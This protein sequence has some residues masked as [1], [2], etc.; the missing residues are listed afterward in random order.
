[1]DTPVDRKEIYNLVGIAI[2]SAQ[3]FEN[4]FVLTAKYV[5]K[6]KYADPAEAFDYKI[7]KQATSSI[8]K[9]LGNTQSIDTELSGR[10]S[11]LLEGRHKIVHRAFLEIGWPH[12]IP[13]CKLIEFRSLCLH[14]ASES[15]QL[16]VILL[17]LL[18]QWIKRFPELTEFMQ[19]TELAYAETVERI[20][21]QTT[22]LI[23]P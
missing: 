17:E 18:G 14:V 12:E 11:L 16:A 3:I 13:E 8:L 15:Q 9:E 6:N 4:V 19:E 23:G 1:M 2:A 22:A 7:F 5:L 10:I 21:S 20:R